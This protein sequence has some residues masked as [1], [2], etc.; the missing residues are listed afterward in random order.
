MAQK[1]SGNGKNK[2]V[3]QKYNYSAQMTAQGTQGFSGKPKTLNAT[4]SVYICNG[5]TFYHVGKNIT[6]Y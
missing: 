2:I 6:K 5:M 1:K 4:Q 3:K